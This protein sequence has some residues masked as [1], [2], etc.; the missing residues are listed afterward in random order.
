MIIIIS[1]V[2]SEKTNK[3]GADAACKRCRLPGDP[4]L[5]G[6]LGCGWK[7]GPRSRPCEPPAPTCP[8]SRGGVPRAGAGPCWASRPLSHGE[9]LLYTRR[10]RRGRVWGRPVRPVQEHPLLVAVPWRGWG[11][12]GGSPAPCSPQLCPA[13]A[14]ARPPAPGT[15]IPGEDRSLLPRDWPD[16]TCL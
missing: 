13:G 16:W 3:R 6:I 8:G 1:S 2:A 5:G 7:G 9:R 12:A 10:P 15:V 14:E 11:A 4:H